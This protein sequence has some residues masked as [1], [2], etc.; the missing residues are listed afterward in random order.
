MWVFRSKS[1][2]R[3]LEVRKAVQPA[4]PFFWRRFLDAGGVGGL[5]V[6]VCLYGVVLVMD[7]WPVDPLP[8]RAGQYLPADVRSRLTFEIPSPK[9]VLP[10]PAED[11]ATPASFRLDDGLMRRIA[12]ELK[13]LPRVLLESSRPQPATQPAT[14]MPAASTQPAT[15]PAPAQIPREAVVELVGPGGLEE[16]D[17]R[18]ETLLAELR[19]QCIL[20]ADEARRQVDRKA[21]NLHLYGAAPDPVVRPVT[22]ILSADEDSQIGQ[23]GVEQ[24]RERLVELVKPFAGPIASQVLARLENIFITEKNALYLYDKQRTEKDIIKP[25]APAPAAA[26][27]VYRR[28]E[29][30]VAASRRQL[31]PDVE[32]LSAL[33]AAEWELLNLEHAAYKGAER[34]LH[35][36]RLWGRFAGR[37][38]VLLAVIAAM[39]IYVVRYDQQV[40]RS[41]WQSLRVAAVLAIMLALGKVATFVLGWNPNAVV[42]P[43]MM[44]TIVLAI[45]YDQRFAMALGSFLAFLAV[46]QLRAP[47]SLLMILAAAVAMSA[48]HLREIRTRS[49]LVRLAVIT[50]S[51]VFAMVWAQ[52]WIA[53]TPARFSLI[54]ALW[55]GGS[56]LLAG[57]LIQGLLPIIERVFCVATSMTLLEWCDASKPLLRTL[58]MQAPGTYNHSLQLGAMCEAGADAIGARG[59]L[60]RTG[61]YYHDVGKINKAE[62]FVENQQGSASKHAKLSPAMSLLIVTG[63]VKDG[64]ELASEYNLPPVLHEFIA[65]HHGTTLVQ[66]FYHAAAEQRKTSAESAPDEME[67]RYPGPKPHSREAA[68]LMLADAA[69]SSVRSMAEPTPGRIENQVHAMVTRRL[70]DGQLDECDLKLSEVH[71]IEDSLVRS[72]CGVHHSR[73][74][75]PTPEGEKPSAAEMP[76]AKSAPTE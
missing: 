74:A 38:G 37:A 44:G 11:D 8:Y 15:M 62:Y 72:L 76:Q 29:V 61:A 70:M 36:W 64:L 71:E 63:H 17:R 43:V 16:Y 21:R 57:F 26:P 28:G 18:V 56:A 75:Y 60:A 33:S 34:K 41:F 52:G 39:C 53:S 13:E 2:Q 12:G 67:F 45:A 31:A 25:A 5:L 27:K 4:R 6:V 48:F 9:T 55:A 73:I 10:E 20:Q 42:L 65:T 23:L 35:P 51:A 50:A 59:L 54:D 7:I 49:K 69:E 47:L 22:S 58:A 30:L 3:R 14:S 46:L 32:E 24:L 68:I 19:R 66:Y 1:R 40:A